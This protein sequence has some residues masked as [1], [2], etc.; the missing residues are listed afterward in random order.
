MGTSWLLPRLIGASRSHELMLTGRRVNAEEALRIGLVADV[1][2]PDA[3]AE[4]ALSGARADREL[5]AVGGAADQ[6]RDLDGARDPLRA[7]GDRVR[8]P[9]ADH[10]DVRQR[11]ARGGRRRSWRS[12]RRSSPTDERAVRHLRPHRARDRRLAR[13]RR[14]DR[15]RA[16]ARPA[17][18]SL[19]SSRK[20]AELLSTAEE[21]A[22][23]RQLPGDPGGPVLAGGSQRARRSGA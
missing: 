23:A 18:T 19:I 22:H 9:P 15:P 10:G 21:L 20:E 6:A 5:G 16:R 7:G 14:D 12:A 1:V 8:G 11:A 17:P 3:L 13:R 2:E 4:R